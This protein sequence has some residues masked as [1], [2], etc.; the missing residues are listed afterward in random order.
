MGHPPHFTATGG[1]NY[2]KKKRALAKEGSYRGYGSSFVDWVSA[3]ISF[4]K[5]AKKGFSVVSHLSMTSFSLY[6]YLST[7]TEGVHFTI[8]KTKF[9]CLLKTYTL[10]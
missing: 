6:L 9:I 2:N 1:Q 7:V 5:G 10:N 4:K 8:T 3:A